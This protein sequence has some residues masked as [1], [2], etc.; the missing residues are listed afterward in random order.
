MPIHAAPRRAAAVL[1]S[2]RS[3]L[4]APG[5]TSA[6]ARRRRGPAR[7]GARACTSRGARRGDWGDGFDH[8]TLNPAPARAAARGR[9]P[10]TR[11]RCGRPGSGAPATAACA[12]P[13]RGS[14]PRPWPW[15]ACPGAP[16]GRPRAQ[17]SAQAPQAPEQGSRRTPHSRT[18]LA[19]PVTLANPLPRVRLW[20]CTNVPARQAARRASAR[21]AGGPARARAP[22]PGRS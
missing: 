5:G 20:I 2:R 16:P 12:P 1:V 14:C 22:W 4:S 7:G 19:W 21:S 6:R 11:A 8:L 9:R 13:Q 3:P 10:G 15:P 18:P 17:R